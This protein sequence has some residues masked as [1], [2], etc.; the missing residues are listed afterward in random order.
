MLDNTQNMLFFVW[1]FFWRDNKEEKYLGLISMK[2][3]K[4]LK[5]DTSHYLWI[6]HH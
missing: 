4:S 1:F 6:H 3:N 2:K 5:I